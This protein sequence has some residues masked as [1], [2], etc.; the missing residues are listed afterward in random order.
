LVITTVAE[1]K[2]L[3]HVPR[4]KFPPPGPL[5]RI[6]LSALVALLGT[7]ALG[8]SR[9]G[10]RMRPSLRVAV[11]LIA[12]VLVGMLVACEDY[13]NPI[14]INPEVNGTPSGTY[15]IPL[16]GTLGNGSG[17]TRT[18]TVNLSVLP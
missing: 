3:P 10:R 6:I 4:F 13:V 2:L 11:L 16:T 7:I 14:N 12:I 17:V 1:S 18:T 5:R 15:S 9:S 8:L